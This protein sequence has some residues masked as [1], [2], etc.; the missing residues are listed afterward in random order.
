MK[1]LITGASS[2][3]GLEM[4]KKLARRKCELILVAR[5]KEKL[6]I[7]QQ[8]LPTKTTIIATDLSNE[9][10]VKELYIVTRKENI[11]ILINNAGFGICDNYDNISLSKE[12]E[13]INTNVKAIQ[14]LT[15]SYLRDM[16]KRDSGYIMNVASIAGLQPGGPLMSSYYASKAYVCSLTSGINCELKKRNSK[17]QVSCLCPGPVNTNFNNVAGVKFSL[18]GIDAKY[19]AEYGLDKMFEGKR[20]IIP[21]TKMKIIAFAKKFLPD[22]LLLNIAYK[23]QKKKQQ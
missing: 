15:K 18:K 12:I 14:I 20:I 2:G 1:A 23:I 8:Q 17:V 6:E 7:I 21:G 16:I 9:Q 13:M 22:N 10:K 4:A 19:V 3:I 11:D 5:S